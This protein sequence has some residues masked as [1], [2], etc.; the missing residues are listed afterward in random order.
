MNNTKL[1]M[2]VFLVDDKGNRKILVERN[3]LYDIIWEYENEDS[4]ELL[5]EK[6]IKTVNKEYLKFA[7]PVVK[8]A[9]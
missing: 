9:A 6:Q 8:E 2:V 3:G 5:T 1:Y 7:V 4:H